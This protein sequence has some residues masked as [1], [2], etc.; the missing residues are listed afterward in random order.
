MQVASVTAAGQ[1]AVLQCHPNGEATFVAA[2]VTSQPRWAQTIAVAARHRTRWRAA[3]RVAIRRNIH[4]EAAAA[5]DEQDAQSHSAK[6]AATIG[7]NRR[8]RREMAVIRPSD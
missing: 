3:R 5:L 8:A 2:V 1:C 7:A 6:E 4:L